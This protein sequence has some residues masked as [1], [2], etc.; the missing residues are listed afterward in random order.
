MSATTRTATEA[1]HA[2]LDMCSHC[3]TNPFNLCPV[4]ATLLRQVPSEPL[5]L[6]RTPHTPRRARR[7]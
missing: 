3:A 6:P 7:S 4:G 1:F 2:H 5:P